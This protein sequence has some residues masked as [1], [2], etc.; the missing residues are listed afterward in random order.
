VDQLPSGVYR[1]R[2]SAGSDPLRGKRHDLTEIVPAR[3]R[4]AAEAE[5][6]RTRLLSHVDEQRNPQTRATG[7]TLTSAGGRASLRR[8]PDYF[9]LPD[10]LAVSVAL[11][12][13]ELS[14]ARLVELLRCCSTRP[15]REIRRRARWSCGSPRR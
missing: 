11:H 7:V 8:V 13:G 4:T 14:E 1:A 6:A 2:A 15:G 9:G 3:P 12:L 5:K 10:P